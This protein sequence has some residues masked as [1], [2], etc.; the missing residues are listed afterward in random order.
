MDIQ[1]LSTT[2][3]VRELGEQDI[4]TIFELYRGNPLYFHHCPPPASPEGVQEDMTILPEGKTADDKYYIGF[5][6]EKELGSEHS[7]KNM[8]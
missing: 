2:Y 1:L 6:K 4:P 5:W 7:G 3:E 8:K